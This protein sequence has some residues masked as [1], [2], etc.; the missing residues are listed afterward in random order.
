M[1]L[2]IPIHFNPSKQIM[3]LII[4]YMLNAQNAQLNTII[5]KSQQ[6]K[7]LMHTKE[8]LETDKMKL[9]ENLKSAE[10][11]MV[12]SLQHLQIIICLLHIHNVLIDVFI[13][14]G[15]FESLTVQ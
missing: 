6:I 12:S 4:E 5:D 9:K 13:L 3:Q 2:Y 14:S 10:N 15:Y 11:T 1:L 7:S 8:K